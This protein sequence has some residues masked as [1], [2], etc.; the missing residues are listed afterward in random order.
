V[1]ATLEADLSAI[2][3]FERLVS[4]R[5]FHRLFPDEDTVEPGGSVKNLTEAHPVTGRPGSRGSPT[6]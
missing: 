4:Q 5:L 3:D 1:S 2:E 6:G